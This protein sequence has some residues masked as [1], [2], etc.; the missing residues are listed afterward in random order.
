MPI[1]QQ[2]KARDDTLTIRKKLV[3][4]QLSENI[5]IHLQPSIAGNV[6]YVV[7]GEISRREAHYERY[8]RAV[9]REAFFTSPLVG[10][11]YRLGIG[12]LVAD[13]LSQFVNDV[14]QG[15]YDSEDPMVSSGKGLAAELA[16]VMQ[17]GGMWGEARA[18]DEAIALAEDDGDLR[19]KG[20]AFLEWYSAEHP[21]LSYSWH[22]V[23]LDDGTQR[24]NGIRKRPVVDIGIGKKGVIEVV[25]RSGFALQYNLESGASDLQILQELPSD[26]SED[27]NE[28]RLQKDTG[29]RIGKQVIESAIRTRR[30][31]GMDSDAIF[32][33]EAALFA[34]Y[35]HKR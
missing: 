17:F 2:Q 32:P 5:P 8:L 21:K 20:V 13:S 9:G 28:R 18:L 15:A 10:L 23:E 25:K 4:T 6:A 27:E 12:S 33:T 30:L 19:E 31:S 16:H 11:E 26:Y 24:I 34:I 14:R 22:K 1:L 35:R 29:V 7:G 3:S